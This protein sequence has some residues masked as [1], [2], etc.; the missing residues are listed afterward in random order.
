M[1]PE[2]W[3][4]IT[5]RHDRLRNLVDNHGTPTHRDVLQLLAD[6][7]DLITERINRRQK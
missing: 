6:E 7:G 1:H 4:Q 5:A 3:N 2:R